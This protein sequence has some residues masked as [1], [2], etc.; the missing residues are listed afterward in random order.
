VRDLFAYLTVNA[1]QLPREDATTLDAEFSR[2]GGFL[3]EL[4][5]EGEA[6]SNLD[7]LRRSKALVHQAYEK[8]KLRDERSARRTL[9]EAEAL[10]TS[11]ITKKPSPPGTPPPPDVS[12]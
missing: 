5:S 11:V 3:N 10:F 8:F 6:G 9:F 1:P 7:Y 4:I 12:D 2:L